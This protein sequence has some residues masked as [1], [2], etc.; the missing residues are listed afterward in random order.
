MPFPFKRF[1]KI[2][3]TINKLWLKHHYN[4]HVILITNN[5]MFNKTDNKVHNN[6]IMNVVENIKYLY[7]HL[8]FNVLSNQFIQML[9]NP[10]H[11]DKTNI[12]ACR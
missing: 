11:L 1:S 9:H 7:K 4:K 6:L 5:K 12:N 3:L 8:R 10:E 2:S